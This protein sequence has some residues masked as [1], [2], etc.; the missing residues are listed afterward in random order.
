MDSTSLDNLLSTMT[1]LMGSL[2]EHLEASDK[3]LEMLVDRQIILEERLN[4]LYNQMK[5]EKP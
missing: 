1:K 4:M 5:D 3:L 2:M